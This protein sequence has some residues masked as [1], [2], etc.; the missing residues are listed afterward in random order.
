MRKNAF[1]E[2]YQE[3]GLKAL[4]H[5]AKHH[6]SRVRACTKFQGGAVRTKTHPHNMDIQGLCVGF[7]NVFDAPRLHEPLLGTPV[8]H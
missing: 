1:V 5:L 7:G 4:N 6:E 8:R 3:Q 2:F